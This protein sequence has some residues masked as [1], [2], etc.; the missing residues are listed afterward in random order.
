M[1]RWMQGWIGEWVGG[2]MDGGM[3]GGMDG[4]VGGWMDGW[5]DEQMNVC[6]AYATDMKDGSELA[7]SRFFH[8]FKTI[9]VTLP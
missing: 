1:G 7:P 2:W 5:T 6:R 4:L 9:L 8:L 3:G